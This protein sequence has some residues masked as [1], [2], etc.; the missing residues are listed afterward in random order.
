[1]EIS[2]TKP[3]Y[4]ADTGHLSLVGNSDNVFMRSW[5]AVIPVKS[6]RNDIRNKKLNIVYRHGCSDINGP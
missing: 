1:M 3:K 6:M 2:Q 4:V 5:L